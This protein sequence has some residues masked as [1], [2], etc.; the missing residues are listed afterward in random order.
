MARPG[1][2]WYRSD[3]DAWFV[4][5]NG[6]QTPLCVRGKENRGEAVRAWHRLMAQ[7][8]EPAQEVSTV[9]EV[10]TAFLADA[11]VR[12]APITHSFYRRFLDPFRTKYGHV[13]VDRITVA[14]AESWSRVATWSSSTRHDALGTLATA[15]RWAERC[16]VVDRSP[17]VGLRLPPK[18]SQGAEAVISKADYDRII[19]AASGDFQALLRFLWLTGCRPSEA[20]ALT[21]DAIDW[22]SASIVLKRHKTANRGKARVIYL[23]DEA[24]AL[25]TAQR[26]RHGCS[27]LFRNQSGTVFGR[28]MLAQKMWRLSKSLGVRVTAYGFRHTFATDAL[29]SGVPDAHVAELLGHSGTAMLHKHYSHLGSK[30]Q[31]LRAALDRVRRA[32]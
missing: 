16:G 21:V 7:R 13:R 18:E 30:A 28:K 3:R 29:V 15:F 20:T 32:G 6:K 25:L 19:Q 26:D 22:A 8:P 31:A 24:L 17:L 11:E 4:K 5:V 1:K 10:I 9:S 23:C 2:P 14:L 12:V 27:L